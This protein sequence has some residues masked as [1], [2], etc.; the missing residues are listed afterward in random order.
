MALGAD[1]DY[2][3][4]RLLHQA[5]NEGLDPE[6]IRR[7][8]R[9]ERTGRSGAEGTATGSRSLDAT[10]CRRAA[11]HLEPTSAQ[12]THGGDRGIARKRASPR[13]GSLRR[14]R[15]TDEA[16]PGGRDLGARLRRRAKGHVLAARA[17][18]GLW[19]RRRERGERSGSTIIGSGDT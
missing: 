3:F 7:C 17:V 9:A 5:C 8:L 16:A 12:G 1:P 14:R 6:S 11:G 19:G 10:R 15:P 13:A 2:L 4:A 18:G